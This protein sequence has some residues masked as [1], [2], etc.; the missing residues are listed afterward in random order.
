MCSRYK[1]MS[2]R[3]KY[4]KDRILG[5]HPIQKLKIILTGLYVAVISDFS[6]AY[7]L[8]LSVPV[9]GFSFFFRQ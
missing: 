4:K 2:D 7:K 6:V 1:T 5:Y 9:L 3:K 8:V